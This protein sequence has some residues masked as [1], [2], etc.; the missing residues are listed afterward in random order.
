ML[1][2]IGDRIDAGQASIAADVDQYLASLREG[3][4]RQV[5]ESE[6]RIAAGR[7]AT[8]HW[9]QNFYDDDAEGVDTSVGPQ[10]SRD[11]SGSGGPATPGPGSAGQPNSRDAELAEAE[12][13]ERIRRLSL[14]DYAQERQRLIR[15]GSPGMF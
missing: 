12:E 9:L 14:Q 7:D 11:A 10:I 3:V 4:A 15:A 1:D 2:V 13:A 8:A 6:A 5:A